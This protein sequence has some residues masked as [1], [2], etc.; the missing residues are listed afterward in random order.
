MAKG[1]AKGFK[2][3]SVRIQEPAMEQ[4]Y[5]L[6]EDNQYVI[7]RE[8]SGIP[9][10]YCSK[11]GTAINGIAKRV[12]AESN[13]QGVL[14]LKEYVDSFETISNNIINSVKI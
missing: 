11:L 8:G 3:V 12:T 1:K 4:Y 10:G 5:I 13:N 7:M 6:N 2:K 9:V 14:S